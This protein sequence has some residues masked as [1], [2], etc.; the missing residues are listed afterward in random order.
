[1]M[2]Q[3]EMI[4][5][6]TIDKYVIERHR[7]AMNTVFTDRYG[8]QFRIERIFAVSELQMNYA[9]IKYLE[10]TERTNADRCLRRIHMTPF[11]TVVTEICNDYEAALVIEEWKKIVNGKIVPKQDTLLIK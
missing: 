7:K 6:E 9:R 2:Q 11:H 5:R 3:P 10:P 8:D 4:F 1:M